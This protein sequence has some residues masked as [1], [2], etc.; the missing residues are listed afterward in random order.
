MSRGE[1]T[2]AELVRVARERFAERGYAAVGTEEIVRAARVTRGA[3]YHHFTDKRD[4]FRAVHEQLEAGLVESIAAR[5]GS[6]EDPL[7]LIATG[8]RLFL[9][10]CTEPA[11][12]RIALTDA[13]GVL[14]W[15]QWR[16][17]D[18]RYGMGLVVAAL[19]NA[20]DAGALRRQPVR[21]LAHLVLGALGEAAFMIANSADPEQARREVEPPL[22]GLL[23]GMRA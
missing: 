19:Q 13:P 21:P 4:L 22:M 20:M 11:F 16:E 10:D 14:G 5:I 6:I 9:D 18:A 3:L 2:R 8:L 7:E 12:M 15:E 23:D 17:I 1:A